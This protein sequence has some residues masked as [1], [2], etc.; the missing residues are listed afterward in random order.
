MNGY[1]FFNSIM[2]KKNYVPNMFRVSIR[3]V[4]II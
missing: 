4:Y 2:L 1:S 3:V